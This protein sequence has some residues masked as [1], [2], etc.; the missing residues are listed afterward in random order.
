MIISI[1]Y[2]FKKIRVR[3]SGEFNVCLKSIKNLTANSA[4]KMR[5]EYANNRLK[6]M[7]I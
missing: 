6:Y 2:S 5:K 3:K 1:S 4:M 7:V